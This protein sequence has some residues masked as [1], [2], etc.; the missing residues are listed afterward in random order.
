VKYGIIPEK[1]IAV[2]ELASAAGLELIPLKMRNPLITTTRGVGEMIIDALNKG[3]KR[4]ILGIGDSATIDCG[5][6]ALSILGVKFLDCDGKEIEKNCQGLLKLAEVDD[7][8]LC[9]EIKDIKLLVGA[10]VSNILTGRDGAVVYARQKGADRKTIP[11]I[12]KALR[13]FQRVVLKRYGVDLDTI[14]GS[15]AAGGIGG[16]LKAILGAKL[17]PGFELIRKYIKIE[18]QIKENELVITGEGRVDQQT[19]AGKAIGQVLNIA[20]RFNRPVV[21]VAGSFVSGMKELSGP[22][23]KEMYSIKRAGERIPSPDV[24]ARRLVR[25]GYELGLRIRKGLL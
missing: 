6:G 10:D 22:A 3:F 17:V 18:K 25:F 16:A 11:V 1:K 15:G 5:I 24:T 7:S 19:F 14:P 21:L 23:V 20:Q 13:N 2:L 12:K 8:E 4:I 9:E